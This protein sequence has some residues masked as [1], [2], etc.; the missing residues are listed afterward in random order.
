[1]RRFAPLFLCALAVVGCG[2]DP[3]KQCDPV[4][5]TGCAS[6]QVCETV[7]NGA[8]PACFDPVVVRGKVFDLATQVALPGARLVALDANRAPVSAVVTSAQDGTYQLDVPSQRKADGTPLAAAVT[9]RADA[10]AYQSFPGGVRLALPID[11]SG[12]TH[13]GGAWTVQSSLTE[14]G[15]IKLPAG[16]GTAA[17]HG[18]VALP[19]DHGGVLVV[20]ET[21]TPAKGTTAIADRSG[22]YAIFNLAPGDYTVTAY[23]H[24]EN[25]APATVT[26]AAG[27]DAAVDL[28]IANGTTATVGGGLIFNSGAITPTS[29]SLVVKSTYSSSLDRGEAPPGLVAAVPTGSTYSFTGVPDGAYVALA[30]FGIDGDV[31]DVS[32]VGNT[33][34][35]DVVVQ[36]GAVVGGGTLAQFK[37]VGAIDLTTIDGVAV[38]DSGK[39]IALTSANPAFVWVKAP[40]Y[41]SAATYAVDVFDAFGNDIWN[42]TTTA[43]N[44]NTVTYAGPTLARGMY[45]QLRIR[46]RDG[47]AT[48]ISQT[49]DLKGVFYLP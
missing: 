14:V 5:G 11:V 35:V 42:V 17:L 29:V 4:A 18:K 25:F 28:A 27:Q 7:E 3:K 46:A 16:A 8:A 20:A 21:G 24:S 9:L 43:V 36:A 26:L 34:A 10:K 48:Q 37:L 39:T 45:Y 2:S 47:A 41:S 15:L 19:S 31:R 33:A 30:A 22:A 12:A 13:A 49:E 1:M 23:A 6:T 38:D 40:S 32:G 44:S